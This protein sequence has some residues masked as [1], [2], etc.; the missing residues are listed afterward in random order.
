MPGILPPR[1]HDANFADEAGERAHPDPVFGSAEGL[2][3]C[4]DVGEQQ[5]VSEKFV[6]PG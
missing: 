1:A 3:Q 4:V 5:R 2:Q 6:D